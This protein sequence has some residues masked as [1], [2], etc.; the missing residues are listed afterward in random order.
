MACEGAGATVRVS[1][2][3]VWQVGGFADVEAAAGTTEDVDVVAHSDDDGIVTWGGSSTIRP[4]PGS[5]M[6]EPLGSPKADPDGES[7]TK[8]VNALRLGPR[9][10]SLRAPFDLNPAPP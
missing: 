7:N 8:E 1:F 4:E 5:A 2:E 6:S 10:A 9:T 3:A